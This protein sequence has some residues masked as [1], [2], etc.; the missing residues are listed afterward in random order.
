MS[1]NVNEV[2]DSLEKLRVEKSPLCDNLGKVVKGFNVIRTVN[3][4]RHVKIFSG[5][6]PVY[7]H[8]DAFNNVVDKLEQSHLNYNIENFKVNEKQG[9]NSVHVTFGFPE[10][11]WDVDGSKTIATFEQI[12]SV[13]GLMKYTELFGLYRLVC[14]NGVIIGKTVYQ[15]KQKKTKNFLDRLDDFD[16]FYNAL[17]AAKEFGK[18]FEKSQQVKVTKKFTDLLIKSGFSSRVINNLPEFFLKY[19]DEYKET[20]KDYTKL[21]A[22]WAILTNYLTHKVAVT[23]IKRAAVMNQRLTSLMINELS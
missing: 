17:L 9:R 22:Y 20:I 2:R 3:E 5:K 12:N 18:L 1:Y 11:A 8:I 14:S 15:Q 6:Y 16:S 23:D 10:I 19:S 7:Q 13:D 4:K 21:W